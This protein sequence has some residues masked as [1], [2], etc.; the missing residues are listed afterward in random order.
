MLLTDAKLK[1]YAGNELDLPDTGVLEVMMAAEPDLARRA[2]V[3]LVER[4]L[5][6]PVSGGL[7]LESPRVASLR[8]AADGATAAALPFVLRRPI[9]LPIGAGLAAALLCAGIGYVAG[10]ASAPAGPVS[11]GR[12]ENSAVHAA[13]DRVPTG[14]TEK[15][16]DGTFRAVAS[17]ISG[18]GALCREFS[19]AADSGTSQVVACRHR[20][21]WT[22]GFALVEPADGA[23]YAPADGSDAIGAFLQSL[24]ATHPLTESAEKDLLGQSP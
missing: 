13:L 18:R 4:R 17:F 24:G 16:R 5:S 9:A 12:I 10:Q 15:L 19:L 22:V 23:D 6:E 21:D 20:T 11:L 3:A 8:L 14:G 2:V 1:A 7:P